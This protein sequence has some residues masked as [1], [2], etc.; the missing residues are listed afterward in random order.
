[1]IPEPSFDH[2]HHHCPYHLTM[3]IVIGWGL[4]E[5][6]KQCFEKEGQIDTLCC[7]LILTDSIPVC[8]L[9]CL[10]QKPATRSISLGYIVHVCLYKK[11]SAWYVASLYGLFGANFLNSEPIQQNSS[12]WKCILYTTY[13]SVLYVVHTQ[14]WKVVLTADCALLV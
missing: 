10:L 9:H 1:M 3:I 5:W 2:L 6:V 12:I 11:E 8:F 4:L 7:S 13:E 14:F